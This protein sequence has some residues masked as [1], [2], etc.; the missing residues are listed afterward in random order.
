MYCVAHQYAPKGVAGEPAASDAVNSIIIASEVF[1]T[2]CRDLSCNTRSCCEASPYILM[3][4]HV[5][6]SRRQGG[7]LAGR[8]ASM[9]LF[10]FFFF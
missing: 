8:Q 2:A 3:L 5:H 1:L 7:S 9:S 4:R 6:A 10:I